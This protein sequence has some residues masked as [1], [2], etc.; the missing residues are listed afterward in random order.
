[1]TDPPEP[2]YQ[3][4]KNPARLAAELLQHYSFELAGYSLVRQIEIW[5]DYYPVEWLPAA[6]T[7]ALYQGRYKAFSVEQI[8][9]LWQ[10]RGTPVHHFN[11]EFERLICSKL[12]IRDPE[13]PP[14]P[15]DDIATYPTVPLSSSQS[16]SY[17][18]ILLELP[19]IRAASKLDRLG[20]IPSLRFD[21]S[22][23]GAPDAA[24]DAAAEPPQRDLDG[25]GNVVRGA[26]DFTDLDINHFADAE[27]TPAGTPVDQLGEELPR[28]EHTRDRPSPPERERVE[29]P[30][31]DPPSLGPYRSGRSIPA[32][33]PQPTNGTR[34]LHSVTDAAK[35]APPPTAPDPSFQDFKEGVV[36]GLSCGLAVV[37][38][39]PRLRLE[40]SQRYHPNWLAYLP[41]NPAIALLQPDTTAGDRNSLT[42]E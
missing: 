5:M 39:H 37:S 15:D 40:L 12:S 10:R 34:P 14:A 11:H 38:L 41:P 2:L 26:W 18:K 25:S 21:Q 22:A 28:D 16:L 29:L 32:L 1:M 31:L 3:P 35:V 8:L 13:P 20:E 42:A 4:S 27:T 6:I 30:N 19:S 17:R 7:E 23:S 24:P 9:N 33:S 36:F